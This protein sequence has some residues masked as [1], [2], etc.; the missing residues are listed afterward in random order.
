MRS[1]DGALL[2]RCYV[3]AVSQSQGVSK[4]EPDFTAA[5]RPADGAKNPQNH[6][7]DHENA[8]DC[9]Q[10]AEAWNEISDDDQNDPENDHDNSVS[11][12]GFQVSS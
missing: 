1:P 11:V 6:A 10:D 9:V 8:A 5:H 3:P 4:L 12:F 7:N 2:W